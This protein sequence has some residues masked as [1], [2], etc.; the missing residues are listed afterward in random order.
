MMLLDF[1]AVDGVPAV[2]GIP[3]VAEI[4]VLLASFLYS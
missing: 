2:V 3:T 1:P 4:P